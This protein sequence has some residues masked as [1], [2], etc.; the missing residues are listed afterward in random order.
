MKNLDGNHTPLVS[1]VIPSFNKSDLLI[2]MIDG[3]F[4]QT[5][6]RW[7]LIIVDD[8]SD[9]ENFNN[10]HSFVSA[11]ERCT[12][13][14]RS[15]EPKNGDTCRNIGMEMAKGEFL[16]IFDADDIIAPTCLENRVKFM[17][18]HPDCDYASF[19]YARFNNGDKWPFKDVK[20]LFNVVPEERMISHF[21]KADYPFTVWSNIYRTDVVKKIKW[22]E[23]VYVYQDFDFM[24]NCIHARLRH[25][26]CD[27]EPDYFYRQFVDGLN[28][29]GSFVSTNKNDSNIYLFSK[30]LDNLKGRDLYEFY[31]KDFF[32]FIVLQYQRLLMGSTKE[33]V[34]KYITLIKKYYSRSFRFA[35]TRNLVGLKS[36]RT[37]TLIV[38]YI[39]GIV[40]G[41][42]DFVKTANYLLIHRLKKV[43]TGKD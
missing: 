40:F 8:G 36:G 42:K 5:Y 27:G 22:D 20:K 35:M 21:L 29:S 24:I 26:Y 32:D 28:V 38:D 1:I 15:R 4:K 2:E 23:K 17:I 10:V 19:P 11:D 34:D 37:K 33:N 25:M 16:I 31:K 14:R 7:E 13:L 43:L 41:R 3:I 39:M 9:E 30:T 18:D 6:K 12:Y